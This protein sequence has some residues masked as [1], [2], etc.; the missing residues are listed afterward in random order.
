MLP[1]SKTFI[2]YEEQHKSD[3]KIVP[4]KHRKLDV[5]LLKFKYNSNLISAA[6]SFGCKQRVLTN[7]D[8]RKFMFSKT[9]RSTGFFVFLPTLK[10][11]LKKT[12]G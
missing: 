3:L 5:V 1:I 2:N 12:K 6:K 8:D 9:Q 11:K 4:V 10:T 7:S